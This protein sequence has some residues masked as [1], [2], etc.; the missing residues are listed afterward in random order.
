M[1]ITTLLGIAVAAVKRGESEGVKV[2]HNPD[3]SVAVT[4]DENIVMG[5]WEEPEINPCRGC[6]DYD[7][8]GGCK[9]N[10]GCGARMDAPTHK[11]VGKA[12]KALGA[13]HDC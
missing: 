10:G 4:I 11:S 13:T 12:L 1:D 5:Y 9:S 6:T 3:G 8:H 2:K 7:G